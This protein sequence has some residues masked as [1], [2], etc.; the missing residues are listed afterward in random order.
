MDHPNRK[1]CMNAALK[2]LS[3]RDHGRREL[4]RKLE[5]RGFDTEDIQTVLG[6]CERLRYV[7]D[8]KYALHLTRHLRRKGYGVHRIQHNLKNKGLA[9]HQITKAIEAEC[10]EDNQITDCRR[11]LQKKLRQVGGGRLLPEVRSRVYRFLFQRGF[12][13]DTIRGVMDEF[14]ANVD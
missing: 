4:Q 14:T 2:I 11:V 9:S 10:A 1:T 6:E 12:P 5:R 3:L 13:A 8:R 7:D